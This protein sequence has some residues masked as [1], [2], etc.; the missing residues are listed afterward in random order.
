[1]SSNVPEESL[2]LKRVGLISFLITELHLLRVCNPLARSA[3][4]FFELMAFSVR[5]QNPPKAFKTIQNRSKHLER[6][7]TLDVTV[8]CDSQDDR[9]LQTAQISLKRCRFPYIFRVTH[10]RAGMLGNLKLI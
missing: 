7:P 4:V 9:F 6:D 5:V 2:Q 3:G 10:H 8:V 1:M